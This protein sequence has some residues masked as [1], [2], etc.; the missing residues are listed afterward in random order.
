MPFHREINQAYETLSKPEIRATYDEYLANPNQNEYYHYY[1]FYKAKYGPQTDP[2]L[3]VVVVLSLFS[4]F[5]YLIR[6]SM[7]E[8]ALNYVENTT[9]FKTLLKQRI[10]D[11]TESKYR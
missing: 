2:K 7:Y 6:K 11:E 4:F 10:Q 1:R 8:R 9:K 5:Q 3:V